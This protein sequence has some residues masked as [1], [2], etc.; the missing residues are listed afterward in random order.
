MK[1]EDIK[2]LKGK[3]FTSVSCSKSDDR[4]EFKNESETICVGHVQDCCECVSIEEIHGTLCDLI[5]TPILHA[6]YT[7]KTNKNPSDEEGQWT[8]YHFATIKGYVDVRWYGESNG[9]YSIG[10]DVWKDGDRW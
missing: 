2:L 6:Y 1:F 8:F 9:Y 3:T 10:V 4:I 5:G 7:E